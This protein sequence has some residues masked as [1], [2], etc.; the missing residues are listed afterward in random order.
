MSLGVDGS[1]LVLSLE[2]RGPRLGDHAPES[3]PAVDSDVLIEGLDLA[4]DAAGLDPEGV[5]VIASD[6]DVV[7]DLR[8]R[9][10]VVVAPVESTVTGT[11]SFAHGDGFGRS[12]EELEPDLTSVRV[13]WN[14]GDDADV[15]KEQALGLTKLAAWLHETDRKLLVEVVVPP[16]ATDLE[17]VGGD[18]GRFVTELRP[19]LSVEAVR[20]IRELGTEADLWAV[21]QG[22]DSGDLG[23]LVTDAGRDAVGVLLIV[24]GTDR[25]LDPP[26]DHVRGMLIDRSAWR[27]GL[28]G[29]RTVDADAV[30]T[31]LSR[32][33][34]LH[35]ARRSS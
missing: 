4:R 16:G 29:A 31:A 14:P 13:R 23:S 34:E 22:A 3:G 9:G 12:V 10:F 26:A 15:K 35:A 5:A 18:H 33:T 30:A 19:S 24:T 20:E 1:L 32:F 27:A 7:R 17:A 11:L 28:A 21:E 2:A 6:T 25:P 8:A